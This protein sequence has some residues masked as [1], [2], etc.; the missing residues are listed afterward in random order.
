MCCALIWLAGAAY[1]GEKSD[2]HGHEQE[3]EHEGVALDAATLHAAG[4]SRA[5]AG[6]HSI[7]ASI[8]VNGRLALNEN[9]TTHLVPRF[10]GV[11]RQVRK[12]QGDS[13]DRGEVVAVVE[14]N[15]NLQPYEIKSPIRG[16]LIRGHAHNGEFVSE[17]EAIFVV[18]DLSRLWAEMFVFSQDFSRVRP[19]QKLVIRAENS[20][21]STQ[22]AVDFISAVVD[23]KT[24]SKFIRAYIDNRDSRW[25]PG[26]FITGDIIVDEA[27]VPVAVEASAIN[28]AEGSYVVFIPEDERI[29]AVPVTLGRTDGHYAEVLSGLAAG[30]H[31]FAGKTSIIKAE[32]DKG[33]AD[34]QH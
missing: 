33:K 23:E 10:P 25:Y 2:H 6:A 22:T 34:H 24:Q 1:A 17:A 14:S 27:L 16:V 12:R 28:R 29:E 11:L 31:Y 30:E 19:G 20:E 7:R 13:V 26:Q 8:R 3:G 9:E 18:S 32:L 4:I 5:V 15:E 21:Q